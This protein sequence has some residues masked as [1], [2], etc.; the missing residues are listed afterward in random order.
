MRAAFVLVF[1]TIFAP[2][3]TV[4]QEIQSPKDGDAKPL[5]TY[6]VEITEVHLSGEAAQRLKV[7]E[8]AQSLEQLTK[9]GHVDL[10]ETVRVSVLLHHESMATFGKQTSV[11]RGVAIAPGGQQQRSMTA[12]RIGTTVQVSAEPHDEHVLLKL[13]YEASRL[14]KDISDDR[15]P[16]TEL[17][18]FSSDLLLRPGKPVVALGSTAKDGTFLLVSIAE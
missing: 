2:A 6:V 1:A 17:V 12:M 15:S 10:L 16:D 3:L 13:K 14:G 18:N 7:N 8:L 5:Q 11:T 4:A 9:D